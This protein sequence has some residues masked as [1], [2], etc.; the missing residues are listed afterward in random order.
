MMP[1]FNLLSTVAGL[2][3][4]VC[5][6][7]ASAMGPMG[8]TVH[9]D[10][11][12]NQIPMIT[13][14]EVEALT[15]AA[16]NYQTAPAY[17][18]APAYQSAPMYQTAPVMQGQTVYSGAMHAPTL[19]APAPIVHGTTLHGAAP[20]GAVPVLQPASAPLAAPA[21][22]YVDTPVMAPP[23]LEVMAPQVAA[24]PVMMP[25]S[26]GWGAQMYVTPRLH[27]VRQNQTA[28]WALGT[29][30][31]NDY[32][33]G[34]GGSVAAGYGRQTGW[35]ALRGELE[36]GYDRAG[37]S[38]HNALGLVVATDE[39][40]FGSTQALYGF[41]NVYGDLAVTESVNLTAGGG[42]GVGRVKFDG[43][44]VTGAAH[45]M[46]DADTALGYHLDAGVSYDLSDSLA[47]E[48]LYRYQSFVDVELDAADGTASEIDIDSHRLSLGAR[49]GF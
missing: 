22:I 45:I 13:L 19:H 29:T 39:D 15:H 9:Y 38:E 4:A 11:H 34:F 33:M 40:A 17:Q 3:L 8:G 37:I 36:V 2:S 16:T 24:K 10:A 25:K 32:G 30:V 31:E 1:R 44:G 5:A 49:I 14:S 41:A 43:H 46:D 18:A 20:H 47:V 23:V 27:A 35:G 21:P 42:I 28:F 6:S 26:N 12:N 48:A 7:G